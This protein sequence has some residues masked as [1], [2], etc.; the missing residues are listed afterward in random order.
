MGSLVAAAG[1]VCVSSEVHFNVTREETVCPDAKS[2]GGFS[3]LIRDESRLI[4]EDD[5]ENERK[6]ELVIR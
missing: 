4:R 1:R 5:D 3:F 6:G 2:T